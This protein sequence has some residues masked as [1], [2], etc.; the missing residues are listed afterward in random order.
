MLRHYKEHGA[1]QPVKMTEEDE[2]YFAEKKIAVTCGEFMQVKFCY[3]RV[4]EWQYGNRSR[5][6]V[7]ELHMPA[8]CLYP[9]QIEAHP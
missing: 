7:R 1:Q 8:L 5:I 9:R 6:G 2:V 4:D 3:H